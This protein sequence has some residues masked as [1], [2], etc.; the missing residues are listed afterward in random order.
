MTSTDPAAA[1]PP[2]RAAVADPARLAAVASY[3]LGGHAGDADLDAVVAYMARAVKAPIAIINLVGPNEQ[4]YPAEHGAGAADSQVPDHLSF[5]S[6]VVATRAPLQ[7]AD[8]REHP[9]FRDN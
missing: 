9:V 5:C 6:Y 7:V 1:L 4:C 2:P 8:A 3:R